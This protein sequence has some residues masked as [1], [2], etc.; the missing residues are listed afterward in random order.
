MAKAMTY[1]ALAADKYHDTLVGDKVNTATTIFVDY[2]DVLT[3]R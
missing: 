1:E 2:Y 3:L